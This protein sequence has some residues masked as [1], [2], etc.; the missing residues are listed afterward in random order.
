MSGSKGKKTKEDFT[1]FLLGDESSPDKT[2]LLP[3]KN[4]KTKSHLKN[5]PKDLPVLEKK[6]NSEPALEPEERAPDATI[7]KSDT[8][9]SQDVVQE[10]KSKTETPIEVVA[11]VSVKKE[12][13][14]LQ[15]HSAPRR[16]LSD[17]LDPSLISIE[18]ALKQA[19]YLKLAQER[20]EHLESKIAELTQENET[21]ASSAHVLQRKHD[22]LLS[23]YDNMV[24]QMTSEK[25]AFRDD[26]VLKDRVIKELEKQNDALKKKND[27]FQAIMNERIQQVRMRERE[28]MNRLEILQLEEDAVISNKD[29]I[30][31][32]LKKQIDKLNYEV[33]IYKAQG[34]QMN[35]TLQAQKEQMRKTVKALKLAL[36]I[37]E[38][39]D[40]VDEIKKTGS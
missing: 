8:S 39:E 37:L 33:E 9:I 36:N 14:K 29:E 19:E 20:I 23:K 5:I 16:V 26:L 32:N 24:Q 28:L 31:I 3:E 7:K 17:V 11:E 12:Q 25:E 6:K 13:P 10:K 21:L 30:L 35:A 38:H 1:I 18:A 27:E 22:E 4:E 34:R 2:V 40:V 15:S